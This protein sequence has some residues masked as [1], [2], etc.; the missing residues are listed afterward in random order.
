MVN[1]NDNFLKAPKIKR[2]AY[3]RCFNIDVESGDAIEIK[4]FKTYKKKV[5]TNN[6][7][8]IKI[9]AFLKD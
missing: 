4:I 6:P 9:I 5:N 7:K 8:D 2:T 1:T 3:K